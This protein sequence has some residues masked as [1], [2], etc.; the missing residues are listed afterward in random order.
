MSTNVREE[1]VKLI[2][3]GKQVKGSYNE[4]KKSQRQVVKNLKGMTEEHKDYQKESMKLTRIT[5]ELGR[6]DGKIKQISKTFNKQKSVWASAK[7]TFA[8]TFG[9]L[10]VDRAI[11]GVIDLSKQL[12]TFVKDLTNHRRAITRLTDVTGHDLDIVSSKIQSIVDTYDQGFT[13]TLTAANGFSK[14]MGIELTDALELMQD[15]FALGA[16]GSQEFL[17]ILKE[18]PAQF[19]AA[20]LSAEQSI[21][22]ITQQVKSG[23]FSDKGADTIKEG[24]LRLREMTKA[25]KDALKGIGLSSVELEKQLKSGTITY[26]EAI[27]MVS[28][29]LDELPPQS[30]IV[31]TA[32][33]DIFGGAGEDAGLE[34]LKSIG[35]IQLELEKTETPI[36][37]LADAN[38][39]LALS[40]QALA[41]EDGLFTKFEI[42]AKQAATASLTLLDIFNKNG[43]IASLNAM[44]NP[45]GAYKYFATN[46]VNQDI[47]TAPMGPQSQSGMEGLV[48]PKKPENTTPTKTPGSVSQS[49]IESATDTPL[50]EFDFSF[51]TSLDEAG[52]ETF[53][54]LTE[55]TLSFQETFIDANQEMIDADLDRTIR[56]I[57]NSELRQAQAQ[58]E[59]ALKEQ[60][61]ELAVLQGMQSVENA[62]S[63]K[64]YGKV[65]LGSAKKIIQA[66]IA[67]GIAAAIT[68]QLGTGPLGIFTAGAAGIAAQG[69]FN[70]IIPSFYFGGPTGSK[71]LGFGD[72]YGDFAGFTHTDEYVVPKN[73]RADPYFAN[74]E[75]YLEGRKKFGM[76][77][78]ISSTQ[79]NINTSVNLTNTESIERAGEKMLE[80]VVLLQQGVPTYF[81][82]DEL[83][84]GIE[85]REQKTATQDRGK[86]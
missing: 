51:I 47:D 14:Q 86:I 4:L 10:T 35:S 44:I 48:I 62:E 56:E 55:A 40:Y 3:D 29:K 12:V 50:D 22:I 42:G 78:D 37:R 26:F 16:E 7:S 54:G 79:S 8:G 31:G 30:A 85:D 13:E 17:S 6:V 80:A 74:T 69:L 34:Y 64:D 39:R 84:K 23:I 82:R 72:Q 73:Q 5:E 83:R 58:E 52:K 19:K 65:L 43:F 49:A 75:R 33:A 2:V 76:T 70:Q 25:T 20:G 45:T 1:V 81:S 27:Q 9:A 67:K 21:A 57:E 36:T 63:L 71:G 61:I 28:N 66:E 59:L 15:G 41:D 46:A 11:S 18:Y 24:T 77:G 32:I 60:Q 68:S 53:E 38:E